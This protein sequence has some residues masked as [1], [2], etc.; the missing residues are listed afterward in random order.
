MSLEIVVTARISIDSHARRSYHDANEPHLAKASWAVFHALEAAYPHYTVLWV[1]ADLE[2]TWL[3]R[4][5]RHVET[6]AVTPEP[7]KTAVTPDSTNGDHDP[8]DPPLPG[9]LT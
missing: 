7:P 3:K 4:Q 5:G 1:N 2:E 8:H 9:E 6:T